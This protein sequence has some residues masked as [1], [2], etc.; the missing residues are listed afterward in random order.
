M[1][2]F[3]GQNFS[4]FLV[5]Q[6][7]CLNTLRLTNLDTTYSFLKDKIKTFF[8]S[9]EAYIISKLGDANFGFPDRIMA[10]NDNIFLINDN[11]DIYHFDSKGLAKKLSFY[12]DTSVI[13][14]VLP[15]TFLDEIKQ[16]VSSGVSA[17]SPSS[18]FD[19]NDSC[20]F[21]LNYYIDSITY[22]KV[23]YD[24]DS[25]L[26]I[27]PI[28]KPIFAVYNYKDGIVNFQ[29]TPKS[30][31]ELLKKSYL[32]SK[33]RD[34]YVFTKI[35]DNI[36][37][38][39]DDLQDVPLVYFT[40]SNFIIN[41]SITLYNIN[42]TVNV[43]KLR[44][45]ISY[46]PLHT[47][48]KHFIYEFVNGMYMIVDSSDAINVNKSTY[49]LLKYSSN[50]FLNKVYNNTAYKL[51]EVKSTIP[52]TIGNSI[53]IFSKISQKNKYIL[54]ISK[55]DSHGEFICEYN[56]DFPDVNSID[57]MFPFNLGSSFGIYLKYNDDKYSFFKISLNF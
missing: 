9:E 7:S 21:I 23:L 51:K 49:F 47:S 24:S 36:N 12:S 33:F 4:Y 20:I 40:D 11:D 35:L 28:L 53:F 39:S 44:N 32:F 16:Y 43:D 15:R 30:C 1:T 29:H 27:A 6:D 26:A 50:D 46:L 34:T 25:I 37:L 3:A 13:N 38:N 41:D 48:N 22:Q 42:R 2:L 45:Y 31:L 17:F 5:L 10:F 55:Y 56:I 19:L 57:F 52:V 54:Y 18:I 8:S 14:Q